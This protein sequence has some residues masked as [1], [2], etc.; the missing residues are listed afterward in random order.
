MELIPSATEMDPNRRTY[1][2][3]CIYMGVSKNR[4]TPKLM[5]YSGTSYKNGRFGSIPIFGN[6]HIYIYT[7]T[8]IYIYY[9]VKGEF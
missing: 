6:T 7:Y 8:Y 9:S 1:Y 3:K 5:V 2:F 4:G